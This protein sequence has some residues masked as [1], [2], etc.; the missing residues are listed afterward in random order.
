MDS[1]A[2]RRC[3]LVVFGLGLVL[4]VA[5]CVPPTPGPCYPGQFGT[6][7]LISPADFETVASL[8]PTL[9]WNDPGGLGCVPTGYRIELATNPSFSGAVIG[10]HAN[11]P[12]T[13]WS[14]NS[15]LFPGTEY[16]W[17]VAAIT[18]QPGR[19]LYGEYSAARRFYTG[20][21]CHAEDLAAPSLNLPLDGETIDILL[22]TL[23]WNNENPDCVP[24]SFLIFLSTDSRFSDTSLNGATGNPATAWSPSVDLVDCTHY[25]WQIVPFVVTT[26][27]PSSEVW[28]FY[29]DV[30]N[31]CLPS[32]MHSSEI[33][34]ECF[35][36]AIRN[37]IC[38][39]SDYVEAEQI[40]VL[41]HGESAGLIA[42][43]PE[44]THG[45]FEL[46]SEQQCW[47]SLEMMDGPE[48]PLQTCGVPIVDPEPKPE[49]AACSPDMEQEACEASGGEWDEGRAGATDCICPEG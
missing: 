20:P 5:A 21:Y 16:W 22:P 33:P 37:P 32:P 48:D 46:A 1:R 38:R 28:S 25:F 44:L 39:L 14:P 6:P 17:K 9:S 8:T 41:E 24:E 2:F 4:V 10:G 45:Q 34:Q 23:D 15:P 13:T 40:A 49:Q 35:Y 42:L 12:D 7:V 3:L 36:K 47:I 26:A 31:T 11:Y 29:V 27:G 19:I 30:T 43:N 18:E